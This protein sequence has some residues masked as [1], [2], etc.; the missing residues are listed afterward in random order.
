MKL[1]RVTGQIDGWSGGLEAFCTNPACGGRNGSPLA[2]QIHGTDYHGEKL[3]DDLRLY[4]CRFCEHRFEVEMPSSN[5]PEVAPVV[6]PG[7]ASITVRCPWCGHP[8]EHKAELWP[9]VNTGGAF[10]I[11]PI[12]TFGVDCCECHGEYVLR[13]QAE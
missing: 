7:A 6:S 3:P 4:A 13:P 5:L 12:T 8:N 9:D 11:S 10:A 2:E 1:D